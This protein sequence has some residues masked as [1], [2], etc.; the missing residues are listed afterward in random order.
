MASA[1]EKRTHNLLNDGSTPLADA[2]DDRRPAQG[3]LLAAGAGLV[4][5]AAFWAGFLVG[6]LPL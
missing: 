6:K 4:L 5:W 1:K 2:V 3:I